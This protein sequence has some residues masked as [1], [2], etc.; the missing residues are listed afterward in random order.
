M[1]WKGIGPL[2][3]SGASKAQKSD[4]PV[5]ALRVRQ[6]QDAERDSFASSGSAAAV[7][8]DDF[9]RFDAFLQGA[10]AFLQHATGSDSLVA[11]EAST[12]VPAGAICMAA[13]ER[14]N[15]RVVCGEKYSFTVWEGPEQ[16][17]LLDLKEV[18][19]EVKPLQR[20]AEQQSDASGMQAP[21]SDTMLWI[22]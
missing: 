19:L 7:H 20:S 5:L 2:S 10:P 6:H 3:Y 18:H 8:P 15:L 9:A 17:Q 12:S 16:P 21:A 11:L 13:V 1:T 22:A 4:A 14:F